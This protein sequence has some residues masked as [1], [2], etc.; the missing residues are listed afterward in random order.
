MTNNKYERIIHYISSP[1][2]CFI[3][4]DL[5]LTALLMRNLE[6]GFSCKSTFIQGNGT[7]YSSDIVHGLLLL[8]LHHEC[9]KGIGGPQPL[10][11]K[12][13]LGSILGCFTSS[14][15]VKRQMQN[16]FGYIWYESKEA[17]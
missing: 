3:L 2:T 8:N 10:H 11:T 1:L 5:I 12:H 17:L 16:I 4:K 15:C 14:V 13:K 7:M 6:G 9:E